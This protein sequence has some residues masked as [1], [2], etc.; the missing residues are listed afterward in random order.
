MHFVSNSALCTSKRDK[1]NPEYIT[2]RIV[3]D[4][5]NLKNNI[6]VEQIILVYESLGS[7]HYP[8]TFLLHN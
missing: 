8:V 6:P 2:L 3:G 1:I 4:P 5:Y 7:P